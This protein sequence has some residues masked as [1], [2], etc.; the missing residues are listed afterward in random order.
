M[1]LDVSGEIRIKV[2][3]VCLLESLA[4]ESIYIAFRF[5]AG[6]SDF[7]VLHS[8]K[9]CS[10]AHSASSPM[11]WGFSPEVERLGNEGDHSPPF[12]V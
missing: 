10:G 4:S 6:A 1:I 9:I 12:N 8:V 7:S 2:L 11:V 3:N 5:P